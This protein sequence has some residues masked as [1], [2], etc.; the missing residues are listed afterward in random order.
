LTKGV[1]NAIVDK[2]E[3]KEISTIITQLQE[4]KLKQ[5]DAEEKR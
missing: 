5:Q 1:D 3:K 2:E 4:I